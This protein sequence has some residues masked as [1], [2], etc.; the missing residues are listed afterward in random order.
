MVGTWLLPLCLVASCKIKFDM[1]IANY[2]DDE[3]L[4]KSFYREKDESVRSQLIIKHMPLAKYLASILYRRRIDDDVDF[5]D[6]L[7]YANIGL[8]EA[9]DNFDFTRKVSF[10]SFASYRIKGAILNGITTFTEKRDQLTL[11]KRLRKERVDSIS[12]EVNSTFSQLVETTLGLAISFILSDTSLITKEDDFN[13]NAPYQ[14]E[15]LSQLNKELRE[16]L[17][18]LSVSEK[19]VINKHYFEHK[20]FI[21]IAESL[22]IT[23]GRVS[24]IHKNAIK[25][26]RA[27]TSKEQFDGVL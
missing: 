16:L 7:Q 24:Q 12:S 26:L 3:E 21:E 27:Y 6:Y 2:N 9:I 1:E 19:N 8:I 17:D 18:L 13:D 4:W 23:K 11:R 10:S 14:Q 22:N 25:K 15:N 5:E 20:K